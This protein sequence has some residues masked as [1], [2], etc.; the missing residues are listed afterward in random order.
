M[1]VG[2]LNYF[3]RRLRQE[4]TD[5]ERKLWENLRNRELCG[6]KFRRQRPIGPYIVDFC[7]V[8]KKLVIEI[9][10][11]QHMV[12][13][14]KDRERTQELNLRGYKVLRFWDHEVL[15]EPET[16]LEAIRLALEDPHPN[17]LPF[18][19]RVT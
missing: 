6:W 14:V 9:D 2:T 18:R 17:P 11:S 5:A 13:E 16:V 1:R 4:Q 8:E 3:P 12:Q 7:C 10:G 19:E 15:S